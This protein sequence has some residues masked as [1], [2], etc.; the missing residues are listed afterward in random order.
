M[1]GEPSKHKALN[2]C[3]FNVGPPSTTQAQHWNSI[4]STPCVYWVEPP[5]EQHRVSIQCIIANNTSIC[6][7]YRNSKYTEQF[8]TP[9]TEIQKFSTVEK[10]G[11]HMPCAAWVR[12]G[13]IQIIPPVHAHTPGYL[14]P[15]QTA[16]VRGKMTILI[17]DTK[18][19]WD[20]RHSSY[21]GRGARPVV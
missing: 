6:T 9:T 20:C 8:S 14:P 18:L 1:L 2:Q 10:L 13:F 4:D 15:Q 16:G 7:Q 21:G 12:R 17:I 3:C 5:L 11:K 19:R